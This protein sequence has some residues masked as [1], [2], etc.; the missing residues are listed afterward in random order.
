VPTRPRLG[1]RRAGAGGRTRRFGALDPAGA[2]VD[3]AGVNTGLLARC[4]V[5]LFSTTI[6]RLKR[7]WWQRRVRRTRPGGRDRGGAGGA[8]WDAAEAD[9]GAAGPFTGSQPGWVDEFVGG[10]FQYAAAQLAAGVR[11]KLRQAAYT[12]KSSPTGCSPP[13]THPLRPAAGIRHLKAR[14]EAPAAAAVVQPGHGVGNI[15]ICALRVR[16]AAARS[17]C[18]VARRDR[19]RAS[20]WII[21]HAGNGGARPP[22]GVQA[23]AGSAVDR[24]AVAE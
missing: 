10:N 14:P 2:P 24:A 17:R 6:S 4:P 15:T 9:A 23:A 22:L 1:R 5:V 7:D 12:S 3:P 18:T 8:A 19:Y 13:G 21:D 11:R 16:G 20:P